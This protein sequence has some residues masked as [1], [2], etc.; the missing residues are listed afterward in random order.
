M[1]RKANAKHLWNALRRIGRCRKAARAV[2][3]KKEQGKCEAFMECLATNWQVSQSGACRYRK[4]RARQMRSIYGMPCDELAG[5]AKR[6][7]PLPQKKEEGKCEA[8]MEIG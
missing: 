7:V 3:A 4:K 2:T 6:R 1:R 5:V 8:F